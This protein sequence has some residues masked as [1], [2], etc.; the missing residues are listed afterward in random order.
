MLF[1]VVCQQYFKNAGGFCVKGINTK[2]KGI[3]KGC[4]HKHMT[5]ST[6]DFQVFF[7]E[8]AEALLWASGVLDSNQNQK[9]KVPVSVLP[10][11]SS[12]I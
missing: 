6:Q 1:C 3:Y 2:D 10:Q 7:L 12:G 8:T 9:T 5:V 4:I 11:A